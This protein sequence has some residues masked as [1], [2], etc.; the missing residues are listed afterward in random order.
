MTNEIKYQ[1]GLVI[2]PQMTQLDIL[3]PHQVFTSMP[4]TQV[5][6]LWKTK[7]P[8]TSAE[9]LTIVPTTTFA[10]CPTLDVLCIGGGDMGQV[11]MMRERELLEFLALQGKKAKYVT[12]VCTGSLIIAAAGLL[13]GY[14]AATHW[15]L[16]DHLAMLGVEVGTERVVVD[17]SRITGGGVTAGIDFGLVVAAKLCGEETAKTI[18]LVLEYNP[19]PPF[20]AGSPETAGEILVDRV[21]KSAKGIMQASLAQTKETA[22]QLKI[23]N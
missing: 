19:A 6:I 2:Y 23:Q 1:I 3:G 17:R 16:R 7:E 14:R 10:D 15:L 13:Q 4:N 9:G 20:N 11:E 22:K 21:K 12:S 18:Q 8:V 5:H